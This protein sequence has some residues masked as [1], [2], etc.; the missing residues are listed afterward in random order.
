MVN[1]E[2]ILENVRILKSEGDRNIEILGVATDSRIVT[3][4]FVFIAVVGLTVNGHDYIEGAI[5]KGAKMIVCESMPQETVEGV[6]YVQVAQSNVAA[7]HI[8]HNYYGRPTEQLGLIGITGTNG[9][10]TIATIMYRLMRQLGYKAG[11]I[12]TIEIMIDGVSQPTSATTPDQVSVNAVLAQ[13]VD[14]GCDYVFM[15]VSSHAVV[16]E[17]IAGLKFRGGIF[18]N[19][20]HDHLDYHGTFKDYRDA[21]KRF[22]DNLD[23]TAIAISNADDANGKYMLQ[24]C[25]ADN[26]LYSL[27]SVVDYRGRVLSSDFSGSEMDVD[28]SSFHSRLIGR[29]NASNLMAAYGMMDALG[30]SKDEALLGLSS[31]NPPDGRFEF[32]R[33]EDGAV[34]IIDYAHTPDA[35][36]NIL[37][38]VV[39]IKKPRSKLITVV[40][41]GGDRDRAKRPEMAAMAVH[42]SDIVILTSDNP[43]SEDPDTIIEDMEKG[44]AYEDEER[45]L[46]IT[47][48]KQAIKTAAKLAKSDDVIVIA[49]KGHEKYQEI[50]GKKYPFDDRALVMAFFEKT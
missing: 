26:R 47:D 4:G 19:L 11:L 23:E 44:V 14:A 8:A 37:K 36:K 34:A 12:S 22:F 42:Y 28:G 18:T 46:S 49:G 38:S 50:K 35:I 24:N 16:Q 21:K 7:G 45:T 15:E 9:K 2:S 10:T 39:E 33:R 13:M 6:C 30:F 48:R 25:K 41:C 1:G 32:V 31:I 27:R 43:R 20:T 17:R 3:P 29:F 40:G 5:V